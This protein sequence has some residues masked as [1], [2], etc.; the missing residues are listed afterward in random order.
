MTATL[1]DRELARERPYLMGIAYRMLGSTSDAEDVVQEALVRAAAASE[2]RTPRAFLTTVVT[3]L[4]LD[5]LG[6]ARRRRESYVGPS[7]PE[8][9][10]TDDFDADELEQRES[11]TLALL[12]VL[13]ELSPLERAVFVLRDVFD[14]EFA[15]IAQAIERSEPACR[16]LLSR[17]RARVQ[18]AELRRPAPSAEQRAVAHAFFSAVASGDLAALVSVLSDE[19]TLSTDHGGKA[20]AARQTLHGPD[21]VG[22]FLCGLYAK[23]QRGFSGYSVTPL[24]LNGAAA[25]ALRNAD[26]HVEASFTL[27]ISVTPA[28]ARVTAV[29]AM[30]NPDKLRGLTRALQEGLQL[31]TRCES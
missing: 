12:L 31:S 8:P 4:C 2:L 19:V 28:G 11:V 13:E 26:G 18:H 5:E 10:P 17:A 7:M 24:L 30:R 27:E 25:V 15:E 3:R 16:K 23:G 1:S 9:V 29:R 14:L 21:H 22:R 6:R 20:S